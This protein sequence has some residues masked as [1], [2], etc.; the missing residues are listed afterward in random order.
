MGKK[1]KYFRQSNENKQIRRLVNNQ[2]KKHANET[3]RY[4]KTLISRFGKGME[5]IN[6]HKAHLDNKRPRK[7]DESRGMSALLENMPLPKSLQSVLYCIHRYFVFRP[8]K[9]KIFKYG[10]STKYKL[11]SIV[12]AE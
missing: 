6:M 9:K 2:R 12:R 5:H 4:M 8:E 10:S 1:V 7:S 11:V 3:K